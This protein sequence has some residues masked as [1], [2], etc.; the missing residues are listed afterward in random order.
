MGEIDELYKLSNK[1]KEKIS[2]IITDKELKSL[3]AFDEL[4]SFNMA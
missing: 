1:I 2:S 3:L 4:N